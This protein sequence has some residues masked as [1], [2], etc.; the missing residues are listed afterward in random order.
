MS[1]QI[2][3]NVVEN[4][5]N[6][7]AMLSNLNIIVDNSAVINNKVNKKTGLRPNSK[8][9]KVVEMIRQ[10]PNLERKQYI[11]MIIRQFGMSKAGAS[12]YHQNSK[13]YL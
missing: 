4:Y 5:D 7:E 8:Q 12:T 1:N 2:D 3:T 6:I 13:K 9:S 10:N 11:E